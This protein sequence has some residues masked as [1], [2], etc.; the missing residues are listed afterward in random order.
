MLSNFVWYAGPIAGHEARTVSNG[1]TICMNEIFF[2]GI[3]SMQTKKKDCYS[4]LP[5]AENADYV[6]T[7]YEDRH[8]KNL[9]QNSVFK[10]YL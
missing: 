1:R 6:F 4:W 10:P 8:K 3:L 5:T 9:Y 7:G 2:M